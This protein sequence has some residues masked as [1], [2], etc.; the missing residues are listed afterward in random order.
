MNWMSKE[1]TICLVHMEI[2]GSTS[3]K[4]SA[5]TNKQAKRSFQREK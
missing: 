3:E 4:K 2:N 5:K 1:N